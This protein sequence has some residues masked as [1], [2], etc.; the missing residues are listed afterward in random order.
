MINSINV[1]F[2]LSNPVPPETKVFLGANPL[3][4]MKHGFVIPVIIQTPSILC[5]PPVSK[6]IR[7][8]TV[9]ALFDTGASRTSITK[10]IADY[11]EL[12]QV[13]FSKIYT[14]A[15]PATYPDYAVDI[16]FPNAGLK[17]IENIKVGSC[18]LPYKNNLPP[19]LTMANSN[20]GALI[21]RD[22]MARWNIVWNGPTSTV[23]ISD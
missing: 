6:P 18:K 2:T 7:T 4:L 9:M 17:S 3:F 23:F 5:I 22:V 19:D 20:F 12:E 8:I 14:A 11:L 1:E 21:G 15:G 13:G 10:I 16:L